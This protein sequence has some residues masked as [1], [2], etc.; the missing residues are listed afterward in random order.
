MALTKFVLPMMMMMM[1][2]MTT[3]M[4]MTMT[5]FSEREKSSL[6]IHECSPTCWFAWA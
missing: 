2:M 3:T 1:T 6:T 5:M 4:T